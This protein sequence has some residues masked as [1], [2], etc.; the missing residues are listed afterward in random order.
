MQL[1]IFKVILY[2]P[3][4]Q[5]YARVGDFNVSLDRLYLLFP[6]LIMPPFSIIPINGV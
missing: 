2:I 3:C 1:S 5:L 4:G 6:I